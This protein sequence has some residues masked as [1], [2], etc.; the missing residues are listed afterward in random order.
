MIKELKG[1]EA[2]SI[3]D[4]KTNAYHITYFPDSKSAS[5]YFKGCNFRCLGCIRRSCNFDIHL[6]FSRNKGADKKAKELLTVEQIL[7]VL[8]KEKINKLIF[9]GGEPTIDSKFAFLS[10]KLKEKFNSYNLLL[11]NGYIF[12]DIS[13]LDEVCVGI[14]AKTPALHKKYTGKNSG[15]VFGNLKRLSESRVS[16]RTECIFIPDYIGFKEI[17]HIARAISR[18][19]A[20]IPLRIDAYIPV[21]GTNWRRPSQKEMR[22]VMI[23]AQKYLKDVTF[24]KGKRS[25]NLIKPLA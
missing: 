6:P 1:E 19:D 2:L 22:E 17:E 10:E 24:I 9:M 12:P 8:S 14:K 13:F 21:P 15:R 23:I 5:L 3:N 18:I 11:T 16:V 4:S 7:N 25:L 20:N